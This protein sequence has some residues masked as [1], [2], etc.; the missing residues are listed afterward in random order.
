MCYPTSPHDVREFLA[1]ARASGRAVH[2]WGNGRSYGDAA[3]NEAGMLIDFSRMNNIVSWEPETGLIQAEPGVTLQQLWR[4]CIEDGYWPPVVSG[5]QRTTLGG[6]LSANAHGKNNW[7]HGPIGDHVVSFEL[8]TVDGTVRL[9]SRESE[10]NLFHAVIG[11]FGLLGMITCVTLQMKRVHSGRLAV[12]AASFENLEQMFSGFQRFNDQ[13]CD[14][15]VG[16]L[17]AFARGDALGRGQIHAARYLQEG[18]DAEGKQYLSVERQEPGRFAFGVVPRSWMWFLAQPWA[19]R[20]GMRLINWGRY[21]WGSKKK[22]QEVHLV[23]HAQFN[24]L[25]DFVPN[26]KRIYAPGGL[27]QYQLFLPKAHALRVMKNVLELQQTLKLESWLVVMKRHR[28]DPFWLSHA[29]DGYSFA[30]DFPVTAKNRETLYKMTKK[31][32]TWVLE[33]GGRFYFAKDSVTS[34]DAFRQSLG[35]EILGRFIGLKRSFDPDFLIQGNLFRRVLRPLV[36]DVP[37]LPLS[38]GEVFSVGEI[39]EEDTPGAEDGENE[40]C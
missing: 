22:G 21:L 15:V 19:H 28:P 35:D 40:S 39:G 34:S 11:G 37:E 6:C 8:I 12:Q 27:I 5:T 20:L 16:W 9:I 29:V 13:E 17:D 1:E 32:E 2:C 33:C 18:K 36:G 23:E 31:F 24:F 3:L 38:E 26:W 10:P 4:H 25:L 7:K 30:M 14:Y